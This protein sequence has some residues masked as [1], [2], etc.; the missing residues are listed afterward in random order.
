M[1]SKAIR[2]QLLAAV[3]MVL[4]AAVALGSS[5]YAWF[6]NSNNVSA[7]GMS[8]TAKSDSS[9]LLILAGQKTTTEIQ[10]AK[11]TTDA[12][13]TANAALYPAAH[14]DIT[15]IVSADL[16]TNW[17]YKYAAAPDA[18]A[19][20][21]DAAELQ[22]TA[23]RLPQYV[24]INE[25]SICT[26]VGSNQMADLK[27]ADL[28]VTTSGDSA[29][30]VIVASET[31]MVEL[32]VGENQTSETVLATSVTDAAVVKIRV[33]IYWD[34]NDDEVYTNNFGNLKATNVNVEFTASPVVA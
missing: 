14:K 4:V 1:N 20:K 34:G 13:I 32:G 22:I 10:T 19:A 8:V 16:N 31:A 28:D 23:E 33:Y 26:A 24:M 2:K 12:A 25:F 6:A 29:V 7:T 3:A 21:A 30:K 15:N 11:K 5:T 27:I 17:Y 18:S 9:Y